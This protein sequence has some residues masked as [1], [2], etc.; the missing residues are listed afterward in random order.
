MPDLLSILARGS[1]HS[2]RKSARAGI[3]VLGRDKARTTGKSRP[4]A[5]KEASVELRLSENQL[6]ELFRFLRESGLFDVGY[7]TITYPD[8]TKAGV[9]ALEHF[10]FHGYLEGRRPN[11]IFDPIWYLTT[12]SDVKIAGIQPLL[13][14][15]QFGEPEGR[16]PSPFFDPK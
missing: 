13:H 7:Y 1:D 2:N 10:Y 12:Y 3:T 5:Q 8:I 14:Y 15:V 16:R 4:N 6:S 11:S 9:D